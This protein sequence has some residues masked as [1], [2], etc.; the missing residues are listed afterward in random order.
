MKKSHPTHRSSSVQTYT[1]DDDSSSGCSS[2][3]D[4]QS[5]GFWNS[6]GKEEESERPRS[7]S[8]SEE[9]SSSFGSFNAGEGTAAQQ[10]QQQKQ[11]ADSTVVSAE[12]ERQI[13]LLMLLAQVCALHDPTPR[14]FTVHVLELY[15]RGILDRDSIGFLFDLGLVPH[16]NDTPLQSPTKLI[17]NGETSPRLTTSTT[18]RGGKEVALQLHQSLDPN[19]LRAQE[20]SSIRS[21]LERQESQT[22]STAKNH[23]N[24]KRTPTFQRSNSEP[25]ETSWAV[26]QH[27]LSLSRY[28]R[29]FLQIRL[30]SSGAFGSVFQA[31]SKMDGRDYAVKRI[32]FSESG[33]SN[34]SVTQVVR[35]VRCLA[36]CDHPHVVRYHTGWLE[37][38]WVTGSGTAVS[39]A[40][41]VASKQVQRRLLTDIHRMVNGGLDSNNNS[42]HD[43][44]NHYDDDDESNSSLDETLD[45]YSHISEWS[46]TRGDS[47][48]TGMQMQAWDKSENR[49]RRAAPKM[50]KKPSYRYQMCFFI[51]MQLCKSTTLADWMRDQNRSGSGIG[52]KEHY[53]AALEVFAQVLK[54][55]EHIHE[56]GIVHRDLKPA[57]C[58]L[59]EDGHFKIGDF[60]LSKVL[61]QATNKGAKVTSPVANSTDLVLVQS[62]AFSSK[63]MNDWEDPLTMGIGT[64]SYCAPEQVSTDCYGV[65]ADIFSLGLILL[66]M[67]CKFGT[68]HERIH[69]FHDCRRGELPEKL[70]QMYPDIAD[71]IASC[72]KH[73]PSERPSASDILSRPLLRQQGED[74]NQG[75]ALQTLR[76]VLQEK[77]TQIEKQQA[78]LDRKD[79]IIADL[80]QQLTQLATKDAASTARS[81]C[82]NVNFN[83]SACTSS[84]S[85]TPDDLTFGIVESTSFSDDD[86]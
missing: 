33:Y 17:A 35:E 47:T 39:S 46:S 63:A 22:A 27:P 76:G 5:S 2:S 43:G 42:S 29:E 85:V 32:C 84:D 69:T 50:Q 21:R 54:G 55:L 65:E 78:E 24:S 58:L 18:E 19:L 10:Q 14:T 80:Q 86:Y 13:L 83:R 70:R 64:A 57:N 40:D 62:K 8:F 77:D 72:T 48:R 51:Q 34:L 75:L 67:L 4:E 31:T 3:K 23:Q 81:A 15:E 49:S 30:L 25:L 26:E 38:S 20:A 71:V 11:Q 61:R 66:E 9:V 44:G 60:G 53:E 12:N 41:D 37:P 73:D 45:N 79:Q 1:D 6:G 68:E 59:G 28:T 36:Q 52:G 74:L 16:Q 82:P 56:A 7:S